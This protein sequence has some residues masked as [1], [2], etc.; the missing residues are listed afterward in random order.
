MGKSS[1]AQGLMG[2]RNLEDK[3]VGRNTEDGVLLV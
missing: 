1:G 2:L 3:N